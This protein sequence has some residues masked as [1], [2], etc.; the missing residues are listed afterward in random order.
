MST[1]YLPDLGEGL[2]EAEISEWHV[3]EGDSVAID[4]TIVSVETAKAIV[5]VP[6][7]QDGVIKSLCASAGDTL[8]TGAPL[9]IFEG[10]TREDSGTVAGTIETSDTVIDTELII[11]RKRSSSSRKTSFAV[12]S[13]AKKLHID[14]EQV[15]GTG[16]NGAITLEDVH[17]FKDK[18]LS[19][20]YEPIKG[21]RKSMAQA[22]SKS[23]AEVV[24]VTIVDD[25]TL[26]AF[27]KDYDITVEIIKAICY[28]VSKEPALNSWLHGASLS[29]QKRDAVD[30]GLAMDTDDG[31]FVPVLWD[32][33]NKTDDQV[34]AQI[35][36]YKSEVGQRSVKP[37]NLSGCS[38]MLSNFGKFAGRY[39][40]PVVVPPTVAILGTGRISEQAVIKNGEQVIAK[41]LPLS[42]SFDHRAITGGEATRFLGA[43]LEHLQKEL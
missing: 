38:I 39:A 36:T 11:G 24:P 31:L 35:N 34:R 41:S 23:H 26:W 10:V 43:I 8:E 2:T 33:A 15:K 12:R 40:N 37:E 14:L 13:L 27:N 1:F 25:A 22:M 18:L 21:V 19:E 3:K 28:A 4:Q 17:G 5:E 20:G 32:A 6:A 30:I 16:V 7:P 42:L 29:V 9:V